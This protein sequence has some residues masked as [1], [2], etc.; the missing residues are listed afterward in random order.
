MLCSVEIK[1]LRGRPLKKYGETLDF[2]SRFPLHFFRALPLSTC[3]TTDQSTVEAS[4]SAVKYFY[5]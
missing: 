4:L 3:F 2:V 5:I 1:A